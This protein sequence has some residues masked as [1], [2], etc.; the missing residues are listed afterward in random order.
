MSCDVLFVHFI[1]DCESLVLP[2][3]QA[4]LQTTAFY[5]FYDL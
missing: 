4:L 5:D 1:G 2:C 3:R